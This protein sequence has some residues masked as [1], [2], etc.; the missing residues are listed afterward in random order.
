MVR[1]AP[2]DTQNLS[3]GQY[4]YDLEVGA[5]GDVFTIL[6]GILTLV[7]EITTTGAI[8]YTTVDW[9]NIEG[10]LSDQTDLQTAL[11]A[12]A[13]TSSLAT[14]ATTGSYSDLTNKPSIPTKTSDLTNDSHFVTSSSL[15]SVATSGNYNDL[16]NKPT[17]LTDFSGV[18]PLTQGGT[19]G[20]TAVEA[21]TNLELMKEY[22]LIDQDVSSGSIITLNDSIMNYR[23]IGICSY[24]PD[25]PQYRGY[26]EFYI[27]SDR[28]FYKIT[29]FVIILTERSIVSRD[30][31][32]G[33]RTARL[34][35]EETSMEYEEHKTFN[36]ETS[37]T[38]TNA[39][40]LI[41]HKIVGYKY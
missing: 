4:Y 3:P 40:D 18:L 25:F 13:N 35:F 16:I 5:N 39:G 7:P 20:E 26:Q 17:Q 14:V 9:G 30:S 28:T 12:K 38:T 29:A 15:A 2:E 23:K 24:D 32:L 1:I 41:V 36:I 10:T 37:G 27:V 19:G 22:V 34:R 31:Y 11:N 8:V 21:R 6:R 33:F